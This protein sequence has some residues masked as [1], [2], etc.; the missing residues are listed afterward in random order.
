M[1]LQGGSVQTSPV[2][3]LTRGDT[4]LTDVNF[5]PTRS[6]SFEHHDRHDAW[7]ILATATIRPADA[8]S[9]VQ[10]PLHRFLSPA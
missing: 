6:P 10:L 7:P 8:G 9:V 3:T 1:T 5:G 2:M 4:F